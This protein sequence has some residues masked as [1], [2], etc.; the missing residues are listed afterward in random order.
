MKELRE[1][2]VS[3]STILYMVTRRQLLISADLQYGDDAKVQPF[4]PTDLGERHAIRFANW[5]DA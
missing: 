5:L 4:S 2:G 1:A 3:R